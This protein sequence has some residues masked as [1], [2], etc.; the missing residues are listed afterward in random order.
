[1]HVVSLSLLQ[2]IWVA[3]LFLA[4]RHLCALCGLVELQVQVH[5]LASDL[6]PFNH[7]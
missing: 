1:M 5:L 6:R 7:D 2:A 4:Y 3:I